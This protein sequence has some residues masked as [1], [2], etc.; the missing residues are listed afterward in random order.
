MKKQKNTE[1][2]LF[3][4]L[5]RLAAEKKLKQSYIA[6]TL[7]YSPQ[8]INSLFRGREQSFSSIFL[9]KLC[10]LLE[11]LDDLKRELY[12]FYGRDSKFEHKLFKI[13]NLSPFDEAWFFNPNFNFIYREP[14]GIFIL[15]T[16]LKPESKYVFW[17]P[18]RTDLE[19]LI[20]PLLANVDNSLLKANL[21]FILG[22]L[23]PLS[24]LHYKISNPGRQN[25]TNYLTSNSAEYIYDSI[26]DDAV[27][28]QRLF[29]FFNP[30]YKGLQKEKKKDDY[31]LV[32]PN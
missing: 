19:N 29:E 31:E 25:Q 13:L 17:S 4:K 24:F 16:F 12:D 10:S 23:N 30:I 7:N 18:N 2:S 26:S 21:S 3:T 27:R 11:V 22:P 14:K 28:G 9:D 32:F 8:H 20:Q 5:K 1:I 15:K 6:R